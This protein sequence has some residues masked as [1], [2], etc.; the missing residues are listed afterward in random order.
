MSNKENGKTIKIGQRQ[1]NDVLIG[2]IDGYEV[3]YSIQ[4]KETPPPERKF[5]PGRGYGVGK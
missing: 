2:K 3:E 4:P 5:D 1:S